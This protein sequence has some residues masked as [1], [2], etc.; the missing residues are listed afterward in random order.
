MAAKASGIDFTELCWRILETSIADVQSAATR[1]V[2][3]G[4]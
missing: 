1:E 4:A 3:H 2:A